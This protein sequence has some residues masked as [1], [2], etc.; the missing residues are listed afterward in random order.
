MLESK[1]KSFF[2]YN[3]FN[4][5]IERKPKIKKVMIPL[6]KINCLATLLTGL[7]L[8]IINYLSII[9][10]AANTTNNNNEAFPDIFSF[11]LGKDRFRIQYEMNS[12]VE[13]KRNNSAGVNLRMN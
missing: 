11:M 12:I 13:N 2:L 7:L 10:E 1:T 9:S 4:H 5:I 8:L 3:L 6:L